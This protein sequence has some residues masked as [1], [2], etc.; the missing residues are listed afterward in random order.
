MYV[1]LPAG[2]RDAIEQALGKRRR[3]RRATA[4]RNGMAAQTDRDAA[5][6]R[7]AAYSAVLTKGGHLG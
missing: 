3:A 6:K 2:K 5:R 1:A 7:L 4:L